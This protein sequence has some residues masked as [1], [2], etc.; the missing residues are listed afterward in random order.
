MSPEP[1]VLAPDVLDTGAAGGK[2]IRGGILRTAGFLIGMLMSLVSVPLMVHHLGPADYGRYITVSSIVFIIGGATEAG[3]TQLGVREYSLLHG[4]ER[5]H[6]LRNIA[7][8]RFVLTAAGVAL[9]VALTA[10]TGAQRAVVEGT[11]IAGLGLLLGLTQQTYAIPLTAHLRLG[12]VS[13]LELLKQT[14]LT[15]LIVA[16]VVIG[17][18]LQ[19]FFV[20]SVGAGL[21]VLAVT[22][23][24]IRREASLRPGADLAVWR[25]VL[26]D[27]LPY[28][29]AAAVGLVYFRLAV[30][31]LSYV[32]SP[33]E[34]GI[35]STAFR[36][37]EVIGVIPWLVV[38]SGFPILA[39]AARDD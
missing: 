33:R 7:G 6:Y 11:A 12:W 19:P 14:V 23:A 26:R 4:A 17:T 13:A 30:V 18:G 35:Y 27:V 39:R 22:L 10:V 15:S 3:L 25:R 20:A 29:V 34:T 36:V 2:A 21:A 31:L 32:A 38:S 24:L 28:A 37:V 16:F 9:A 8:L 5:E 1:P